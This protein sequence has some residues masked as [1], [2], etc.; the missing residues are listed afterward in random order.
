MNQC[1]QRDWVVFAATASTLMAIGN[2]PVSAQDKSAIPPTPPSDGQLQLI[3]LQATPAQQ[4]TATAIFQGCA[5]ANIR[6]YNQAVPNEIEALPL[7]NTNDGY[8][9]SQIALQSIVGDG[10]QDMRAVVVIQDTHHTM[11]PGEGLRDGDS[12]VRKEQ[13]LTVEIS[14][15]MIGT[16]VGTPTLWAG[17]AGMRT[18]QGDFGGFFTPQTSLEEGRALLDTYTGPRAALLRA[19]AAADFIGSMPAGADGAYRVNKIEYCL[20]SAAIK[21]GLLAK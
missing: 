10:R 3:A 20:Q 2:L 6:P 11:V 13:V 21:A 19:A 9:T 18:A 7:E 5:A 8:R 16:Q 17:V 4:K 15:S 1:Y 12:T 14:G